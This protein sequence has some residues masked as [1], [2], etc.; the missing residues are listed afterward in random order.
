MKIRR[1][2]GAYNVLWL[3]ALVVG[4]ILML[5]FL[6]NPTSDTKPP[7]GQ[8]ADTPLSSNNHIAINANNTSGQAHN[9]MNANSVALP[10]LAP[11]TT[12]PISQT[13][14]GYT[15]TLY[16]TYADANLI[17]LTYTVQSSYQDLSRLSPCEPLRGEDSP[18]VASEPVLAGT[19]TPFLLS[20]TGEFYQPRLTGENGHVF[21]WL[22]DASWQV[23]EEPL[24]SPLVFDASQP[25]DTLPKEFKLHLALNKVEFRI[26][27][28][29]AEGT[30]I[31]KVNEAYSF[32]FTL[33][34]DPLRR[35]AEVKQKAVTPEGDT[36]TMERVIATQHDVRAIWRL[37]DSR[38]P[39]P[40]PPARVPYAC[41]RLKLEVGSN[42]PAYLQSYPL[43]KGGFGAREDLVIGS[44]MAEP[45]DWTIST[46]YFSTWPGNMS[47]PDKPGPI[48][49]FTMPSAITSLQP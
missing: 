38:Q 49:H 45:S 22:R 25:T 44:I 20:P 10:Q 36:I 7:P 8:S 35:I 39:F 23:H 33:P 3:A 18:C 15:V 17:V 5:S 28:F 1:L 46:W 26:P 42:E 11:S 6:V 9:A 48:F 34:V 30:Y 13:V 12:T 24:S 32:D 40:I 21:S 41:C 31:R 43:D 29:A 27:G 16:P 37:D 14:N 19:A 2:A 47:Y 4:L